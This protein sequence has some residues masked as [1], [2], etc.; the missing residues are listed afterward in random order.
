MFFL[1]YFFIEK[2]WKRR[3]PFK[4]FRCNL[5]LCIFFLCE[6]LRV[7]LWN[8]AVKQFADQD[9]YRSLKVELWKRWKLSEFRGRGLLWSF[10]LSTRG[11][12]KHAK[13]QTMQTFSVESANWRN[14]FFKLFFLVVR[15]H[16]STLWQQKNSLHGYDVD[17]PL[18]TVSK[19]K[20]KKLF[21][22]CFPR[23]SCFLPFLLRFFIFT[24]C[25]L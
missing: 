22:H 12:I 15:K 17:K 3:D 20:S 24:S 18:I 25:V 5:M 9:N 8:S 11:L 16:H 19:S 1:Y 7:R 4:V 23:R 13:T 10:E 6:S 21:S 2:N 14:K